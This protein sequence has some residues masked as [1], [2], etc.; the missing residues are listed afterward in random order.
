[1]A[2]YVEYIFTVVPPQ[3]GSD[4]LMSDLADLGF[5]SF[6]ENENG[7]SAYIT[8]ENN[9][10]LDVGKIYYSDFTFSYSVKPIEEKN[11]NEVWEKNFEPI[12]VDDKLL[13]RAPFHKADTTIPK[14]IIISPKMSFGT[15]HHDT[16]WLMCKHMLNINFTKKKVLDMG[17]GTGILAILAKKTGAESTTAIDNDLWCVENSKE[18]CEINNCSDIKI[19]HGGGEV[20]PT[21]IKFD[22]ILANINKNVLKQLMPIF[23]EALS[24]KGKLLLS[25]FFSTDVEE[26]QLVIEKNQLKFCTYLSK[27]N[28]ALIEAEK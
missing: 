18:N 22:I 11:W 10:G 17:C 26:L 14:E 20:I 25:G 12:Y 1:M 7:F 4:I 13:V 27:N 16:T 21:D 8:E 5:E 2:V 15:G 24:E 19:I 28:W 23:S 9:R 6:T 3:P